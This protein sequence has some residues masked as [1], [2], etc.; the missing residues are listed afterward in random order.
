L[1]KAANLIIDWV[2]EQ[3]IKDMKIELIQHEKKTPLIF[4]EIAA[5][6]EGSNDRTV[7]AYAHFDKQ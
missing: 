4:A 1:E 2:K 5:F 7:L 3:P 6:G